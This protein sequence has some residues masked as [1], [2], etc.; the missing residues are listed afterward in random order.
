MGGFRPFRQDDVNDGN[1]ANS[2]HSPTAR[3]ATKVDHVVLVLV[4]GQ[5]FNPA[6]IVIRTDGVCR[7]NPEAARVVAMVSATARC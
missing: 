1:R 5:V 2:G 6:D 7:L 3:R 4:K